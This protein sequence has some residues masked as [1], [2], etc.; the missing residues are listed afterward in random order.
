MCA[1]GTIIEVSAETLVRMEGASSRHGRKHVSVT[2][3]ASLE[4]D[5]A[6]P[7]RRTKGGDLCNVDFVYG[8]AQTNS[9]AEDDESLIRNRATCVE[10]A[11]MKGAVI[12]RGHY[13][14]GIDDYGKHPIGC[15]EIPC[16]YTHQDDTVEA[17]GRCMFFNPTD[18][19]PNPAD[20]SALSKPVCSRARYIN[21]VHNSSDCGND[22][23]ELIMQDK[24]CR[25]CA[26]CKGDA[27]S[28]NPTWNVTNAGTQ[29][30]NGSKYDEFPKG[31]LVRDGG[32]VASFNSPVGGQ[33]DN[34]PKNPL[35]TPICMRKDALSPEQVQVL[36][37]E[38]E[39][40][41][42]KGVVVPIDASGSTITTGDHGTSEFTVDGAKVW[43]WEV[44]SGGAA[45]SDGADGHGVASNAGIDFDTEHATADAA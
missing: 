28:L 1:A 8:T 3:S 12:V 41:L 23:F 42:V 6:K 32:S 10:A 37:G 24:L 31:C 27:I 45:S 44:L 11:R 21:G 40:T 36:E 2:G 35:G 13:T 9:C 30:V 16:K 43:G 4:L 25:D 29:P 20:M 7:A 26:S 14:I 15:Y 22:K 19:T 38:M 18:A 17:N 39:D 5:R 33:A 34:D